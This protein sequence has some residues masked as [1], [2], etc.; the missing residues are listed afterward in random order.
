MDVAGGDAGAAGGGGGGAVGEG[1]AF[2]A[3]AEVDEAVEGAHGWGRE[4]GEVGR[5]C[6]GDVGRWM[7]GG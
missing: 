4:G 5:R 1:A 7:G 3:A 2:V 6:V